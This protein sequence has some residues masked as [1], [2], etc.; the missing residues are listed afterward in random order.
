LP[1]SMPAQR[2]ACARLAVP[3]SP[4]PRRP[5]SWCSAGVDGQP[6]GRSLA[7]KAAEAPKAPPAGKTGGDAPG[8]PGFAP[9]D[10]VRE[11]ARYVAR[12]HAGTDILAPVE[13]PRVLQPPS[14]FPAATTGRRLTDGRGCGSQKPAGPGAAAPAAAGGGHGRARDPPGAGGGGGVRAVAGGAA[15]VGA[16]GRAGPGHVSG[17]RLPA[18]ALRS[19]AAP[20]ARPLRKPESDRRLEHALGCAGAAWPPC[21]ARWQGLC[22][23]PASAGRALRARSW[24]A[25]RWAWATAT[26]STPTAARSSCS[27]NSCA[28]PRQRA[29]AGSSPC[30]KLPR[31][32]PWVAACVHDCCIFAHSEAAAACTGRRR[33][34]GS[35]YCGRA[36][37]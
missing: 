9:G 30:L 31:H 11:S 26:C 1:A 20:P 16:P 14:R 28:G 17:V 32:H 18:R 4:A 8:V 27:A 13:C 15:Q 29:S 37:A 24:S 25:R 7:A 19:P 12:A 23:G 35:P 10:G 2:S 6:A 34:Q 3:C 22:R 33:M 36:A 5:T 21:P